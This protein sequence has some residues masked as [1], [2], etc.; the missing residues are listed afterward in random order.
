M[1]DVTEGNI[2]RLALEQL[3]LDLNLDRAYAE[4][5]DLLMALCG[6]RRRRVDWS[7]CDEVRAVACEVDIA[8][9]TESLVATRWV[10]LLRLTHQP[11]FGRLHFPFMHN[12]ASFCRPLSLLLRLPVQPFGIIAV[13]PRELCL[14]PTH[15]RPSIRRL[16]L[17][18][19]PLMVDPGAGM[20]R[21]CV[22]MWQGPTAS[23]LF[24]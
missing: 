13:Q 16:G 19:C 5:I 4:D 1:Q 20:K 15:L 21:L 7:V 22:L 18:N 2:D 11:Q 8:S 17:L 9:V 6:N 3:P 12:I 23:L 10:R 14:F 24:R